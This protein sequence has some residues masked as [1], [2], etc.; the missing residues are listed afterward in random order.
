VPLPTD[1]ETRLSDAKAP[2]SSPSGW[3]DAPMAALTLLIVAGA[4][5]YAFYL[6]R[7]GDGIFRRLLP[8]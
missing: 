1:D 8:A 3:L 4:A 7:A 5:T 2:S 6:S